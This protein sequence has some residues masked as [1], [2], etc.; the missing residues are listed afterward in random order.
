VAAR[1]FVRPDGACYKRA[2]ASIP[3]A[4]YLAVVKR[5]EDRCIY[6]GTQTLGVGR[7]RQRQSNH[8]HIE[9]ILPR[10]RGGLNTMENLAVACVGC[11]LSK[12]NKT[13]GEWTR[14]Q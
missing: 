1:F 3:H 9:H 11:N 8:R 4:V 6:C 10:S 12:N 2:P 5:D 14:G 7:L 13:V